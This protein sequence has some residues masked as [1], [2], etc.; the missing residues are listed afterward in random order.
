MTDRYYQTDDLAEV[1]VLAVH[2][3]HP[4]ETLTLGRQKVMKFEASPYLLEILDS[5]RRGT[6]QV[7]ARM[8]LMVYRDLVTMIRRMT[9]V[10]APAG[11]R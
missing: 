9:T 2:G 5:Y 3:M 1:A 6:L 8:I 7:S 11:D 4:I 10:V